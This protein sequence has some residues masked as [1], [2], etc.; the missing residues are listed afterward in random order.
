MGNVRYVIQSNIRH[1]KIY[2]YKQ[3][4]CA[5]YMIRYKYTY[6]LFMIYK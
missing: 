3:Y 6:T 1:D 5:I 4:I 2:L